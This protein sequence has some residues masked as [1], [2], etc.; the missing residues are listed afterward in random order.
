MYKCF[1]FLGLPPVLCLKHVF[2]RRI[3][4]WFP[5]RIWSQIKVYLYL[6]DYFE[7]RPLSEHLLPDLALLIVLAVQEKNFILEQQEAHVHEMGINEDGDRTPHQPN[8]LHD[9]I[10]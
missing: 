3:S 7:W 8:L 9:F 5:G 10:T 4:T 2:D 1:N 6:S